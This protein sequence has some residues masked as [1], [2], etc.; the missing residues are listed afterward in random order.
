MNANEVYNMGVYEFLNYLAY[1]KSDII[2]RNKEA[3]KAKNKIKKR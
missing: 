1:C 3:E 2:R